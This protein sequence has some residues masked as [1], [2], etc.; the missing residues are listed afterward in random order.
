MKAV[1][2]DG[3]VCYPATSGKRLRTLHLMLRLAR[4]HQITYL[5]RCATG[6][7]EAVQARE[8]LADHG[9]Q[10]VLVDHPVPRKA[11]PLFYA[12]L[13]VNLLSPLPYSVASHTGPLMRQALHTFAAEHEV[14]LWQF[15]WTALADVLGSEP[16]RVRLVVAHNVDSLIWRRYYEAESNFLK[17]WYFKHQW[18]KY[19]GF[20][21]RV[22]SEV[23]GVV[24]VSAEDAAIVR[25]RFG[26][27]SVDVVDNGID[28]AYFEG[29]QGKREPHDI[30]FLGALD[31]RPN[32]DAVAMMLDRVFPAVR[33][34]VPSARLSI[35]GR[36]PAPAL[37]ERI[38][39]LPHVELHANVSDVRP[40]LA[41]SGVMAVPLRVGGGSRL[42]ILEALAC[43][44]PVVSTRVGA[45]GL[46][47]GPDRDL[48]VV[49]DVENMASALVESLR[50]PERLHAMAE[51]G[52]RLVLER[53]DWDALA[54]KLEQVWQRCVR[55]QHARLPE[56]HLV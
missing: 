25:N 48:V 27:S 12:R 17:R 4:R 21:R 32:A 14:D 23:S 19:D 47:L 53:Y 35:V 55:P 38:R 28:R 52:R 49:E 36:N 33:A 31:Y 39:A 41:R 8:F 5:C 40:F 10:T 16:N 15:E 54:D 42:K 56:A 46:C 51:R 2:V 24:T 13:A 18:R 22:F 7:P 6:S 34:Q 9:I 43:G 44:L 11:G 29:V 3:D 37:V 50:T 26:V 20:E 45:E 30:L 1:I